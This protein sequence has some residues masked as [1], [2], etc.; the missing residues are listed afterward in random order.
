MLLDE[1]A[2]SRRVF[3]TLV[4]AQTKALL[5]DFGYRV[6]DEAA[7]ETMNGKAD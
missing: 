4:S 6:A 5:R 2:A 1:S 7:G 3:E